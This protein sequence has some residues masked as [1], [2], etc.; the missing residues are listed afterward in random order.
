MSFSIKSVRN[1]GLLSVKMTDGVNGQVLKTDGKGLFSWIDNNSN[2]ST[3]YCCVDDI[4][5]SFTTDLNLSLLYRQLRVGNFVLG[6]VLYVKVL[7]KIGMAYKWAENQTPLDFFLKVYINNTEQYSNKEGL[8]D[9]PDEWNKLND[10]IILD[11]KKNDVIS[12]KLCR[13]S[14]ETSLQFTIKKNSF[15]LIEL[16]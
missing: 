10:T 15:Y 14:D 4:S 12:I 13:E 2:I 9:Y 3:V 1:P 11:I 5:N 16:L 7:L 8:S 6:D